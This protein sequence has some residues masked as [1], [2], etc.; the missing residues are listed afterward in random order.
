MDYLANHNLV[1]DTILGRD[2]LCH[3]LTDTNYKVGIKYYNYGEIL[4]VATYLS[5]Y[6][7]TK[8]TKSGKVEKSSYS[9]IQTLDDK[10]W[11]LINVI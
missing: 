9:L 11:K 5:Y 4:W 8:K 10:T 2:W 6:N 1:T 3:I 7:A